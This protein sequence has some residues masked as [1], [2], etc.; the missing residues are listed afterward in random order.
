MADLSVDVNLNLKEEGT[1]KAAETFADIVAKGLQKNLRKLGMGEA[2]TAKA[3]KGEVSATN[4]KRPSK[5]DSVRSRR[6][7]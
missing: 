3:S 7:S 4:K 2:F 6:R 5:Q 1:K